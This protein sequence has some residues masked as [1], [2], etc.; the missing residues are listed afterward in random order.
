V[1]VEIDDLIINRISQERR[2]DGTNQPNGILCV[3]VLA[4]G[5]DQRFDVSS[6]NIG[7]LH[8]PKLAVLVDSE[9]DNM[10]MEKLTVAF[11]RLLLKI[12]SD[13]LSQVSA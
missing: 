4:L 2:E 5:C 12:R 1:Q 10:S 9:R 6:P 13:S 3:T 11:A 8:V 7:Q